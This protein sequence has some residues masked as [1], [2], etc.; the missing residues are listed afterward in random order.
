MKTWITSDLH[1][2][3]KNILKF[4]PETRGCFQDVDHMHRDVVKIWNSVVGEDDLVYNLGDVTFGNAYKSAQILQQMNGRQILI[5]GNH[6]SKSL[7]DVNFRN[8]F[9]EVHD[10][11]EIKH[12]GKKVILFHY[13]VSEWRDCHYG[14]VHFY[15]HLHNRTAGV[16]GRCMNVGWDWTGDIVSNLDVLM[17]K[18]LKVDKFVPHHGE[19]SGN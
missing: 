11:L 4:C 17:E 6:D 9:E 8:C 19:T 16:P 14:S 2:F 18:M 7:K 15:G 13:P 10:Y 5:R 12:S 1:L 3:H